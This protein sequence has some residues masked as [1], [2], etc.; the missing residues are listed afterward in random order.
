MLLVIYKN[1]QSSIFFKSATK[2][3]YVLNET[4]G[5]CQEKNLEKTYLN[6]ILMAR[7]NSNLNVIY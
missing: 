6:F 4:R 2:W 1:K 5:V 7:I 3:H